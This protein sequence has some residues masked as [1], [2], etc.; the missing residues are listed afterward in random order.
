[1]TFS[2]FTMKLVPS[3]SCFSGNFY[4]DIIS[5]PKPIN[6]CTDRSV[7]IYDHDQLLIMKSR[8]FAENQVNL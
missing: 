2:Y 3:E 5:M 7:N 1:M 8:Y 4:N 6:V